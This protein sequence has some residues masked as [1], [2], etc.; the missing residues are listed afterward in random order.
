MDYV[1]FTRASSIPGDYHSDDLELRAIVASNGPLEITGSVGQNFI[2]Q[3]QYSSYYDTR[4]YFPVQLEQ[5]LEQKAVSMFPVSGYDELSEP[6]KQMVW[7]EVQ[8]SKLTWDLNVTQTQ[9][10]GDSDI[11]II[12][13]EPW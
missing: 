3:S 10:R 9:V 11:T 1:A 13:T 6:E 12:L 4:N 8:E 2:V 7:R 5:L